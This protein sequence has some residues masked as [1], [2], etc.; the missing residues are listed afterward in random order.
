M[1]LNILPSGDIVVTLSEQN[2]A[3]LI[4]LWD[5][6]SAGEAVPVLHRMTESGLRLSVQIEANE[7]HYNKPERKEGVTGGQS[8]ASLFSSAARAA[9]RL[10]NALQTSLQE[11]VRSRVSKCTVSECRLCATEGPEQDDPAST[12]WENE[13]GALYEY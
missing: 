12:D 7:I 9:L 2:L 1:Q 11:D 5:A 10:A 13:G 4:E 6:A 3:A 8:G